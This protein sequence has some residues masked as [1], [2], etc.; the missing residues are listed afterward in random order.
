MALTDLIIKDKANADVVF[1]FSGLNGASGI[2]TDASRAPDSPRLISAATQ[3]TG[4]KNPVTRSKFRLD[5]Q[6]IGTDGVTPERVTAYTVIE[7][8]AGI[9]SAEILD[10]VAI[11]KNGLTDTNVGKLVAGQLL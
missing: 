8:T 6:S 9:T 11:M 2:Y 5:I 3:K 1:G 7:R 4:G 10:A